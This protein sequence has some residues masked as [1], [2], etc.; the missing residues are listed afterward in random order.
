M[1]YKSNCINKSLHKKNKKIDL[2]IMEL[3]NNG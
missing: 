3:I 1:I 2:I